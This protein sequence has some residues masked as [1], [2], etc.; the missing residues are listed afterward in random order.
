MRF[1]FHEKDF[2]AIIM[3][4]TCQSVYGSAYRWIGNTIMFIKRN[5]GVARL[6]S[7][8]RRGSCSHRPQ[9]HFSRILAAT[10]M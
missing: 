10:V 5:I 1:L 8:A 9:S 7:R 4:P 3:H 2:I 6:V